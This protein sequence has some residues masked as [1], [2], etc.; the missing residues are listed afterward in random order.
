M[1]SV[2]GPDCHDLLHN[3]VNCFLDADTEPA[4]PFL[5]ANWSVYILPS[6]LEKFLTW[7]MQ[8]KRDYSI[9]VHPNSGCELEDHTDWTF[10]GGAPWQLD[11]SIFMDDKTLPQAYE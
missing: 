8:N 4:G 10:W 6:Y 3:D 5:T 2:L 7:T 11:T 9:L 1:S